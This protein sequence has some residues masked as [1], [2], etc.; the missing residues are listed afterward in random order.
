MSWLRPDIPVGAALLDA[1]GRAEALRRAAEFVLDRAA[2]AGG[3]A[4]VGYRREMPPGT[5]GATS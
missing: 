1:L 3:A 5:A 2:G 4:E